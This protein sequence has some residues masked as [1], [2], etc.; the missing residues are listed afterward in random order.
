MV[1]AVTKSQTMCKAQLCPAAPFPLLPHLEPGIARMPQ[2]FPSPK[3][4]TQAPPSPGLLR[5]RKKSEHENVLET[6]LSAPTMLNWHPASRIHGVFA[7]HHPSQQLPSF[8]W[9]GHLVFFQ[10]SRSMSRAP[11]MAAD[12]TPCS[13]Q[14]KLSP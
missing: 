5:T 7:P 11:S 2:N 14:S 4:L 9:F 1:T 8:L 3:M 12:L 13:H 6:E 10:D